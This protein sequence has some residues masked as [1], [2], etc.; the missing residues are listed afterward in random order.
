MKA[1]IKNIELDTKSDKRFP[2]NLLSG[3]LYRVRN[4]LYYVHGS[5][6]IGDDYAKEV[7]T[8]TTEEWNEK[9][10][11]VYKVP[12]EWTEYI[13]LMSADDVIN[14]FINEVSKSVVIIKDAEFLLKYPIITN[15]LTKI[16]LDNCTVNLAGDNTGFININ[17]MS[18]GEN[19]CELDEYIGKLEDLM[20]GYSKILRNVISP[21]KY[22]KYGSKHGQPQI[23]R[24][25]PENTE[26]HFKV[27]RQDQILESSTDKRGYPQSC[28]K[29]NREKCVTVIVHNDVLEPGKEPLH[30]KY[31]DRVIG[32]SMDQNII[33]VDKAITS[34]EELQELVK[35]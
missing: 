4:G 23:K 12:Y 20:T 33:V 31:D 19:N 25:W 26:Y 13:S 5:R 3:S 30:L 9:T 24:H 1:I 15:G 14:L 11:S 28:G 32:V 7:F 8:G 18:T 16:C 29:E 34:V 10:H 2:V 17:S 21:A 35:R 22:Y 27:N 6:P